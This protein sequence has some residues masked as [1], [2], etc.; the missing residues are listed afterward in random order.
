MTPQVV[1]D[2]Q[3]TPRERHCACRFTSLAFF[4]LVVKESLLSS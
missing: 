1:D 2:Q 3:K 4:K